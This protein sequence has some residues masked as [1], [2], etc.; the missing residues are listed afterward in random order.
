M[1]DIPLPTAASSPGTSIEHLTFENDARLM[2]FFKSCSEDT[3]KLLCG[4]NEPL[5]SHPS[6]KKI[7]RLILPSND[8]IIEY[9]PED[10]VISAETSITLGELQAHLL[11]YRQWLPAYASQEVTLLDLLNQAHTGCLEHG[12]GGM[13]ELCLGITAAL[14][15]GHKINAGG[16]V[17]K[18]VT[19]YDLPKLF[20]GARGSLGYLTAANL[21]LSALPSSQLTVCLAYERSTDCLKDAWNLL[22]TGLPISCLE[23][24]NAAQLKLLKTSFAKQPDKNK[25]TEPEIVTPETNQPASYRLI[26]QL[27]ADKEILPDLLKVIHAKTRQAQEYTTITEHD[28]AGK[29]WTALSSLPQKQEAEYI[30]FNFPFKTICLLMQ[31]MGS[32]FQEYAWQMR[33]GKGKLFLRID[34]EKAPSLM[35][36]LGAHLADSQSSFSSVRT[37]RNLTRFYERI[38]YNL[39]IRQI[40]V[41]QTLKETLKQKFDRKRLLNPF[42]Q[43]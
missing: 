10:L 1:T 19:G 34:Q 39:A 5:P 43:L 37:T 7:K 13:R 31:T 38:P 28:E 33:P 29:F 14:T 15:D 8:K 2:E 20:I 23:I 22:Q 32:I 6:T 11:P 17:V 12:F 36:R 16:K 42:V 18:N 25:I 9:S 41:E 21:R 4:L 35:H 27:H 26:C 24:V 40:A 30:S 3:S